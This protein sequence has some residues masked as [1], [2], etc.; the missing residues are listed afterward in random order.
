MTVTKLRAVGSPAPKLDLG[1]VFSTLVDPGEYEVALVRVETGNIWNSKRW[2]GHFQIVQEGESFGL[3]LL[4]VWNQQKGKRLG[5]SSKLF[6]DYKAVVGRLPPAT[7]VTPDMFLKDCQVLAEVVTVTKD[8]R[9]SPQP[10]E[11]WYSKIDWL[12]K[13]T[14]GTP[15]CLQGQR[16][17]T[18]T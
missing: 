11:F 7:G 18:R 4:R 16:A 14:A 10:R 8:Y 15:P 17:S 1:D 13:L 6:A 12:T 3:P 2:F 5:R 9:G